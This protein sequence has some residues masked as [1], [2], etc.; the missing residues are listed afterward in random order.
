MALIVGFRFDHD[1]RQRLRAINGQFLFIDL[2]RKIRMVLGSLAIKSPAAERRRPWVR[3]RGRSVGTNPENFSGAENEHES[4]QGRTLLRDRGDPCA[5]GPAVARPRDIPDGR[6]GDSRRP[7]R[8]GATMYVSS[9]GQSIVQVSST[10]V[11]SPFA[12]L[13]ANSFPE[14]VAVD[15]SGNVYVADDGTSQITRITPGGAVSLFATL[16]ANSGP[17]GLAFDGSGNL[18]AA[19]NGPNQISKIT[20]LGAVSLFA[21][22]PA[23]S[24]PFGL[25][26]GS[27]GSLYVADRGTSQ[28]SRITSSGVVSLFAT[29][30][31]GTNPNGIAFD[32]SGN[33][34]AADNSTNQISKITSG[35]AVSVFATL[36]AGS[37]P[38]GIAFDGGGNLYV[39]DFGTSEINQVSSD[40]LTVTPFATGINQP[41]YIAFAPAAS[42]ASVPLPSGAAM[43]SI[44]VV[45][46][47]IL[48]RGRFLPL[49]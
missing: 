41:R 12:T 1:S 23:G 5:F 47:A 25:A 14:G 43:L 9:G 24:H 44:A 37:N 19:S 18:Y 4:M 21:T 8:P 3:G 6:G 10:G 20:S 46:L 2:R 49:A 17:I 29:L 42:V 27:N 28:I 36:P 34:Y 26:L 13:P 7:R 15:S 40:G 32:S 11:V 33:L 16:P 30:P 39:A 48:M 31:S 22:L 45:S 35:G 38:A